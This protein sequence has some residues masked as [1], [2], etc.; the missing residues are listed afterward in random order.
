MIGC[1]CCNYRNGAGLSLQAPAPAPALQCCSAADF[2]GAAGEVLIPAVSAVSLGLAL[3]VRCSQPGLSSDNTNTS[4]SRDI[5]SLQ[6]ALLANVGVSILSECEV[7]RDAGLYLLLARC[8]G[9]GGADP[10][11]TG[12]AEP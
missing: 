12:A 10:D 3:H 1:N 4:S 2:S 11:H 9:G 7:R 5:C 8:G 6:S